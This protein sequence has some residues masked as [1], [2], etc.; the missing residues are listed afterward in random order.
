[1]LRPCQVDCKSNDREKDKSK[2]ADALDADF[3]AV[4]DKIGETA[5]QNVHSADEKIEKRKK[6]FDRKIGYGCC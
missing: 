6:D 4:T 2:D 5:C 1:V 3:G